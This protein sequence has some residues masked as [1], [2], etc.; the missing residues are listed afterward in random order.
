MLRDFQKEDLQAVSELWLSANLD[1]HD[2]IR[3]SW[4]KKQQAAVRQQLMQAE[5]IVA[6]EGDQICGFIG[7]QGEWVAG[8]F[9]RRQN[10]CAGIGKALLDEAK[11]RHPTLSLSVYR[12]N[13]KAVAFYRREGFVTVRQSAEKDSGMKE[14]TMRWPQNE[15]EGGRSDGSACDRDGIQSAVAAALPAGGRTDSS[16]SAG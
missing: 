6:T 9:V 2:F 16:Y 7:L 3:A 5:V 11:R 10:R 4:W 14:L 13:E 1:A 15:K 8:L 12:R